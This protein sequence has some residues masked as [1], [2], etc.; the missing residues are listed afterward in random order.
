[1]EFHPLVVHITCEP[2]LSAESTDSCVAVGFADDRAV[3]LTGAS[4]F[5]LER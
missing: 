1:M 5:Y 3:S 4:P 2:L